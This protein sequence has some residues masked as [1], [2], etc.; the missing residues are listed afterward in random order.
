LNS[1]YNVLISQERI[2]FEA[3]LDPIPERGRKLVKRKGNS[4]GKS[5][6]GLGS[7]TGLPGK[8]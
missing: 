1:L 2:K 7:T 4:P 5:A 3:D 6:F 8:I